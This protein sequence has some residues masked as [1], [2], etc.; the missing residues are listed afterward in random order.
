MRVFHSERYEYGCEEGVF[1]L[2]EH[3]RLLEETREEM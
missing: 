1:D 2:Q 3:D